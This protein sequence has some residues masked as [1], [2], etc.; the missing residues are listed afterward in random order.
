MEASEVLDAAAGSRSKLTTMI[1][2][3][4]WEDEAFRQRLVADP[5]AAVRRGPARAYQRKPTS[6]TS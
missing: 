3:K 6:P 5:K 4:A 2:R 1:T